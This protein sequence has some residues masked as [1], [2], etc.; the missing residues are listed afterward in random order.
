MY[1][2]NLRDFSPKIMLVQL[3]LSRWIYRTLEQENLPL[4]RKTAQQDND[5]QARTSRGEARTEGR[6]GEYFS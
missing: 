5:V 3:Y 2:T 1:Y 4:L 6:K